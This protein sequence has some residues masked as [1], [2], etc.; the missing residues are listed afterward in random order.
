M[1]GKYFPRYNLLLIEGKSIFIN[2]FE[3]FL[4]KIYILNLYQKQD[5][6]ITISPSAEIFNLLYGCFVS[7]VEE[8]AIKTKNFVKNTNKYCSTVIYFNLQHIDS[9]LEIFNYLDKN[10]IYKTI[11][12]F[13]KNCKKKKINFFIDKINSSIN[14]TSSG[15]VTETHIN[16]KL[17]D[18]L[19]IISF[20]LH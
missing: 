10:S 1:N 6:V 2:A 3:C 19:N 13:I 14:F 18:T 11:N 7:S 16:S 12:K 20:N 5:N 9:N 17:K 4:E 15:I 8:L